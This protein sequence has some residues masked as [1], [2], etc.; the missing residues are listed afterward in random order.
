[1]TG[2]RIKLPKTNYFT[3]LLL[4]TI[5][6]LLVTTAIK[7]KAIKPGE[8]V[9]LLKIYEKWF[10]TRKYE[11]SG[12]YHDDRI[13]WDDVN[14]LFK[15]NFLTNPGFEQGAG[16]LPDIWHI[17]NNAFR[18]DI[19]AHSGNYSL[20]LKGNSSADYPN[21]TVSPKGIY[22]LG[23]WVRLEK[24]KLNVKAHTKVIVRWYDSLN[25]LVSSC[26]IPSSSYH[27]RLCLR[28]SFPEGTG[29]IRYE[30][31]IRAP[32]EARTAC[33]VVKTI[34][35][36]QAY[37][38]DIVLTK[39]TRAAYLGEGSLA[40]PVHFEP[41]E[42]PKIH[43]FN[44]ELFSLDG[45]VR[46]VDSWSAKIDNKTVNIEN[47]AFDS[48]IEMF[49]VQITIPGLEEGKHF[50]QIIAKKGE[51]E[52]TANGQIM[53]FNPGESLLIGVL[54]DIHY[55]PHTLTEAHR[56]FA[57]SMKEVVGQLNAH[58]PDIVAILGDLGGHNQPPACL[59]NDIEAINAPVILGRGN[60]EYD[61]NNELKYDAY[62]SQTQTYFSKTIGSYHLIFMNGNELNPD[63]AHKNT[64]MSQAQLEWIEDE[65]LTNQDKYIIVFTEPSI[66]FWNPA[67]TSFRNS[68]PKQAEK[69]RKLFAKYG[70]K[71]VIQGD[72]HQV[73]KKTVNG[74]RYVT[75]SSP[76][77]PFKQEPW[78]GYGLF[79]FYKGDAKFAGTVEMFHPNLEDPYPPVVWDIVRFNSTHVPDY[80]YT[81][82]A[83]SISRSK[84]MIIFDIENL[85]SNIKNL[86]FH[87]E[88][89]AM[90][91]SGTH[92]ME[93][94][95]K[96]IVELDAGHNRDTIEFKKIG[97]VEVDGSIE[98]DIKKYS[99]LEIEISYQSSGGSVKF[100]FYNLKTEYNYEAFI[101]GI[102]VG[103]YE[104]DENGRIA[105]SFDKIGKHI[106][107]ILAQ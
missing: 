39:Y 49:T 21:I 71:V 82:K 31:I 30:E 7:H 85:S 44:V 86:P 41:S 74:V 83:L 94:N 45:I 88:S 62:F 105:L 11:Y 90:L 19:S 28:P 10:R 40:N 4:F 15:N 17:K 72:K 59:L 18:S 64:I 100:V 9:D 36:I 48:A 78:T 53:V 56:K 98:Y 5:L 37:Y 13:N 80:Y 42:L 34:G 91:N 81:D 75:V 63:G 61:G 1:M 22:S 51:S 84:D 99:D 87:I 29:W 43:K 55:G 96:T 3:S 47:V 107:R 38:D 103:N 66:V 32:L 52:F 104:T 68:F 70:V 26:Q 25:K 69:L 35:D 101:D 65:L 97:C 58:N 33:L 23:Y 2:K 76:T 24:G 102:S 73:L 54:T 20:S 57:E 12:T 27:K 89:G 14:Q 93:S 16:D 95:G 6:I 92:I 50:I 60:H 8:P 77:M 67:Y 106:I 79:L 46:K